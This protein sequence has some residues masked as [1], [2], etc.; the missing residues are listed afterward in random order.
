MR[1]K[2]IFVFRGDIFMNKS[3]KNHFIKM[4][5]ASL[6]ALLVGLYFIILV[7]VISYFQFKDVD[8]MPWVVYG[9]VT[10]LLLSFVALIVINLVKR[11]YEIKGGEE[12]EA[13][14]Y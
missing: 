6:S 8:K 3:D 11:I 12:D 9:I 13:S 1:N 7:I 5:G 4:L 14:K 10:L 2:Y